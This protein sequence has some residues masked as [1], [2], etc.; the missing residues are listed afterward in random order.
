MDHRNARFSNRFIQRIAL[1]NTSF[2]F[3]VKRGKIKIDNETQLSFVSYRTIFRRQT[4]NID[5]QKI[6]QTPGHSSLYTVSGT[7]FLLGGNNLQ[8]QILKREDQKKMSVW[9]VLKCPCH[10]C[11]PGGL[12]MFLV[13]KI[14]CK[15]KYDFR[16]SIFR[17]QYWH[18]L[19]KQPINV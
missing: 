17:Y 10:R 4:N 12:T 9:G 1:V 11:L 19:A 5:M 7:L 14:L 18:V 8:S 3:Y 6:K 13:K 16:G 2:I 15:M